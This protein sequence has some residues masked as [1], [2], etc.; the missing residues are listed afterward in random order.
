MRPVFL[1]C[2]L[3]V[4]I[5]LKVNAQ[6]SPG[7]LSEPHKML[8]GLANCTQCHTAGQQIQAK[9]CLACH[10][11]LNDRISAGEGL[12][13]GREFENCVECHSEHHGRKFKMVHFKE[14]VDNFDHSRTGYD[15]KDAHTE[16][17][18]RDCHNSLNN[19]NAELLMSRKKKPEKTF[20]GLSQDCASCHD[21]THQG[22]LGTACQDCHNEKNWKPATGFDHAKTK[23][24]L[25][26]QHQ[27]LDCLQCHFNTGEPAR[28]AKSLSFKVASF[29]QCSSCHKDVHQG[30]FGSA[31]TDCHNTQSFT[32]LNRGVSFDHS[33]TRFP[34]EGK[35]SKLECR[36]CHKS[37]AFT[38]AIAFQT[39]MSCH[40]DQHNG[41]FTEHASKGD[42]ASCHTVNG[43]QPS[44]FTLVDHGKSSFPLEGAH[45]AIPCFACH[46]EQKP[47][48][49]RSD[50]QLKMNRF[51]IKVEDCSSCHRDPHIGETNS[52]MASEKGCASCHSVESWQDIEFDHSRTNFV[53]EGKHQDVSCSSCHKPMTEKNLRIVRFT[54]TKPICSSCHEDVHDRQFDQKTL[55]N[56][57]L[58][59]F[60]DC[61]RCHSP[62]SWQ[63][64]LF[65][66]T[67]DAAFSLDGAHKK[68]QCRSCHKLTGSTDT[69]VLRFKPLDKTCSSCHG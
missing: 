31:C 56:S 2:V 44:T 8:E 54:S 57:S 59:S 6:L 27:S 10:T 12:H 67:R 65:D 55:I 39:C 35:H 51:T 25:T 5:S 16:L 26:G 18:C 23:F 48:I 60:T 37:G 20:L 13:A 38:G 63:P 29:M 50:Q 15:L 64:E 3:F 30:K 24:K 34:L 58:T 19:P 47:R 49:L 62:N 52:F 68:L 45:R 41:Q 4:L 61:A 17:K 14:G 11:F 1:I 22:E 33:K 46:I 69:N 32:R 42:C 21:D 66:H 53:L 40:K 7:E 43:F 9:N 28:E 36:V